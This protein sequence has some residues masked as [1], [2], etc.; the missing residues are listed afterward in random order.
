[1]ARALLACLIAVAAFAAAVQAAATRP[2][3]R[4]VQKAP[5]TIRGSGFHA[6]ERVRVTVSA[7]G[8]KETRSMRA[9]RT[10]VF[11]VELPATVVYDPCNS[12]LVATA[13]GAGGDS[14]TLKYPQRA[15]PPAP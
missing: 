9:S 14:A 12:S 8:P 11:T 2:T 4:L 3:L 7:D 5:V 13:V 15:C 1:M 10:G 6:G